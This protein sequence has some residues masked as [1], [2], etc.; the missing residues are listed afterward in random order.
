MKSYGFSSPQIQQVLSAY[1]AGALSAGYNAIVSGFVH[2]DDLSVF[3]HRRSGSRHFY[4]W[5]TLFLEEGP[6]IPAN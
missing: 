4:A 6:Q 1:S 3:W 5:P 2:P